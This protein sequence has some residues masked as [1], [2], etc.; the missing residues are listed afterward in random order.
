MIQLWDLEIYCRS[1]G[2]EKD[3]KYSYI[4]NR[5]PKDQVA[6][7]CVAQEDDRPEDEEVQDIGRSLH[8]RA[9]EHTHARL[10]VHVLEDAQNHKEDAAQREALFRT[11]CQE[12]LS[13]R[14]R[15]SVPRGQKVRADA[16]VQSS[17][18]SSRTCVPR[19]VIW[20]QTC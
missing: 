11:S 2:G 17:W 5:P 13:W 18:K 10:E 8:E 9:R 16:C 4:V 12:R 20:A 7:E 6:H 14:K 1:P 15:G 3:K 19:R